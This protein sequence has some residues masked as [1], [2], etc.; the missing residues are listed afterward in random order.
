MSIL[1]VLGRF[2]LIYIVLIITVGLALNYFGI[3]SN[4]SA[5]IGILVGTIF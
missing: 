4:S 2:T 3:G 1:E 5:N